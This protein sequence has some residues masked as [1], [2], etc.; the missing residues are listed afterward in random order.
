[1]TIEKGNPESQGARKGPAMAGNMK[2]EDMDKDLKGRALKICTIL[3]KTYPEAGT[4]LH[5][6][7]PFELLIAT[8]LSAQCTDAKVNEVTPAL[9]ERFGD[10]QSMAGA[11]IDQIEQLIHSTGFYRQKAR[12]IQKCAQALVENHGGVVPESMDELTALP[13]VGRKT[14]NLVRSCAMGKP[15]LIVDT[16]FKRVTGR[17]GLTRQSVPD[18]IEMDIA[19]LLPESRW[20]AFSDA[21]IRHGRALCTARKPQC[22]HCPAQ[23]W[24]EYGQTMH[25]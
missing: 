10:A 2:P 24:C 11:E 22:E 13:G 15:G 1:M 16:H 18:K 9:F 23:T 5:F 8:I 25:S 19:R 21:I 6:K 20:S 17:L 7:T 3:C 14:A 4:A 12:S